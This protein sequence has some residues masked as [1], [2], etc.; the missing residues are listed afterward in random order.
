[1]P[2]HRRPPWSRPT[3]RPYPAR[4]AAPT[5]PPAPPRKPPTALRPDDGL[6][7]A[8]ALDEEVP[9]ETSS[10][11]RDV[12]PTRASS[13]S[14]AR[15]RRG[16]DRLCLQWGAGARPS[17]TVLR[18]EV[19][20]RVPDRATRRAVY[21][22]PRVPY[23]PTRLAGLRNRA[24]GTGVAVGPGPARRGGYAVRVLA[25]QRVRGPNGEGE[26]HAVATLCSS[27]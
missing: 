17:M 5:R 25:R 14:R 16:C 21:C 6:R 4:D 7:C 9:P 27:R 22:G 11:D 3:R 13:P 26:E 24:A 23:R 12:A 15:P 2:W 20:W 10:H 1:M 18:G 8:R 19:A